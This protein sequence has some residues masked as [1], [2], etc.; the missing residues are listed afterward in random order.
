MPSRPTIAAL[1]ASLVLAAGAT[2]CGASGAGPTGPVAAAPPRVGA[3]KIEPSSGPVGT[4]F[5]LSA[6]GLR[7]GEVVAFEI[8]FPGEGKAY[9][10]AALNVATDGTVSTTYRATAANEPGEYLVRLTGPPGSLAEGRFRITA[11]PP[12]TST[13]PSDV[14]PASSSPSTSG[15]TGTTARS[16]RSTTTTAGAGALATTTT[17]ASS[18]TTTVR[19]TTTVATVPSRASTTATT[20]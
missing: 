17:R 20:R 2:A 11:G 7:D 9:P 4:V 16:T 14:A 1:A 13:I 19:A 12:I 3:V 6:S 10:G 15:R 8:A 18:A 5:T